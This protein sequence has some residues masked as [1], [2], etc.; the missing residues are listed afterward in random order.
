MRF[1]KRLI[2]HAPLEKK[3]VKTFEQ[4]YNSIDPD[5]IFT[6]YGMRHKA[7]PEKTGENSR[8]GP[9][10][11]VIVIKREVIIGDT[12]VFK[13]VIYIYECCWDY[14]TNC[15]KITIHEYTKLL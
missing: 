8:R 7:V 12:I 9:N 5:N 6:V 14:R 2:K 13:P 11:P 1:I 15:S 3:P 10:Q 4:A